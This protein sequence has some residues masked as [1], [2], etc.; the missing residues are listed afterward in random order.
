VKRLIFVTHHALEKWHERWPGGVAD[1][2]AAL[3]LISEEVNDALLEGRYSSK[4]PRWAIGPKGS[5]QLSRNGGERDRTKRFCWTPDQR[6]GYLIDR[7]G[8]KIVVVS[9]IRPKVDD[10]LEPW[11]KL[12]PS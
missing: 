10:T 1:S 12:S 4:L 3:L 7:V 6:R 11:P 9:A 8:P 2:D 5:R